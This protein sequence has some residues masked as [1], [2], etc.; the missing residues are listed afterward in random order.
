MD[1]L[2][3]PL[4]GACLCGA[5]QV[6][7][8]AHPLLTVACH[9]RDCQKL[10]ASAFSL[11]AMIPEHGFS[12]TGEVIRGGLGEPTRAHWFCKSCLGFVFS[13]VAWAPHR[14]NLRSSLLEEGASLA[15][16]IEVMTEQKLPWA[17]VDVVHSFARTP[18][19]V[20]ELDALMAAY[21]KANAY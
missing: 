13:R 10:T 19:S 8:T 11:T 20:A 7:V 21:A 18:S 16:F 3:L 1:R 2:P 4:S 17:Q 6:R 14:V 9:C 15:P 12:C 5:A